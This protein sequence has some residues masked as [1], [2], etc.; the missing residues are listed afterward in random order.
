MGRKKDV[1]MQDIADHLSISKVTVSKAFNGQNGVGPDLKERIIEVGRTMGYKMPDSLKSTSGQA[2]HM[3]IFMK[4]KFAQGEESFYLRIYQRLSV[5]LSR[6]G[7]FALLFPVSQRDS[8]EGDVSAMLEGSDISGII[9]L[10]DMGKPFLKGAKDTGL[11]CILVDSY[12]RDSEIDCVVTEN[13]YSMYELTTHLIQN[14][15]TEIGYVG[16]ISATNSIMDR[17]LGYYRAHLSAGI[18]V[19]KDWIIGDRNAD[20]EDVEFTLPEHMPTAFVSNCDDTTYQ[21]VRVLTENGYRVPEDVSIVSFDNDI[22]AE[23]CV[24]KLTTA[25]VNIDLMA[26]KSVEL[27]CDRMGQEQKLPHGVSFINT[28]IIYRDSVKNIS[29]RDDKNGGLQ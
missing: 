15:H 28:T 14:G 20:S 29:V 18:P 26:K 16:N 21:F 8:R 7:Y 19:R 1:T 22:Y 27:I 3:A 2:V 24:P 13:V 5:E 17:F 4:E 6:H 25:A 11:P 9:L 12:D 10:G 23:L